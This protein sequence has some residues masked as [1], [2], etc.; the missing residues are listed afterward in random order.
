MPN[1]VFS[2]SIGELAHGKKSHTQSLNHP[3]RLFDAP[4]TEALALRKSYS[5]KIWKVVCQEHAYFTTSLCNAWTWKQL[6]DI[7]N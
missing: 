2:S 6:I 4:G 7:G 1:F 5:I 3:P